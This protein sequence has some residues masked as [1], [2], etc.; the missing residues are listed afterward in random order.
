[1]QYYI[2]IYICSTIQI[3]FLGVKKTY[4]YEQSQKRYT[5]VIKCEYFWEIE[6]CVQES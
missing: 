1:M 3:W 4:F 5:T 2:T 6:W